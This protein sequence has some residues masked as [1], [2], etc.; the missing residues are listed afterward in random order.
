MEYTVTL[1]AGD[2]IGPE[3][4][5]AAVRCVDAEA[6]SHGF[7]VIWDKQPAGEGAVRAFRTPLPSRTLASVKRNRVALKGPVTTPVSTGYR[8]VNVEI[9]QKLDLFA[10][11]R[12]VRSL[13]GVRS[14]YKGVDIVVIRENTED[15][16]AGIE[17]GKGSRALRML[18]GFVKKETG[19]AIRPGSAVALKPISQYA[20]ERVARF[21]FDFAV[22]GKRRMVTAVHKA[23]IMKFTDGL[24]LRSARKVATRYPRIGFD[25]MIVDNMCMHLVT[26]PGIYDILLCPNLYGDII[27]DLCSGIVGGLGLAPSAEIGER[28]AVFEPVHGSAPKHAGKD[29]V[30]P[31]ACILSAAMMLRHLGEK[32]AARNLESA[33]TDVIKKGR[34]VTYDINSK[35]H[36]G[37]TEMTDAIIERIR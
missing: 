22:S 30:N 20:S 2:G 16:Y 29:D 3:V 13:A 21:A 25:D 28:C 11:V 26:N 37:T 34:H 9:R 19:K 1:I 17:F 4:T 35:S 23:N 32:K 31:S 7:S 8:S 6:E 18:S 24:F 10:N 12:P 5:A 14:C 33:V 15:L 27:S 36:V